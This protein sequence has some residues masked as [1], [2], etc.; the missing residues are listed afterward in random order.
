[1][2]ADPV[3]SRFTLP[4]T[5]FSPSEQKGR[6]VQRGS[7]APA[8]TI[9]IKRTVERRTV[10]VATI[11]AF[12]SVTAGLRCDHSSRISCWIRKCCVFVPLGCIRQIYFVKIER[13][14]G[15]VSERIDFVQ[16]APSCAN[17]EHF[18]VKMQHATCAQHVNI[19]NGNLHQTWAGTKVIALV[20]YI[21]RIRRT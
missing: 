4:T 7:A 1:M 19:S 14:P 21:R 17:V 18:I 16:Q 5:A 3:L 2:N 20:F 10:Q 6:S 12:P 11:V 8:Q 13:W 9:F 15:R